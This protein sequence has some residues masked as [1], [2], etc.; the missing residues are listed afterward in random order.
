V[1]FLKGGRLVGFGYG[2]AISDRRS[3]VEYDL[4]LGVMHPKCLRN[5]VLARV[6]MFVVQPVGPV[7]YD[8]SCS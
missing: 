3:K 6:E 4:R 5:V 7:E 1:S 2:V 8:V